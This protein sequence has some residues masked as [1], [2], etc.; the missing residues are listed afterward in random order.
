MDN[1]LENISVLNPRIY[2][3]II[4]K[5]GQSLIKVVNTVDNDIL[6]NN[7][8][9]ETTKLDREFHGYGIESMRLLVKKYNGY[10]SFNQ[11]ED[12]FSLLIVLPFN[13]SL[14]E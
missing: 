14:I 11:E 5:K 6:K 4:M 8:N 13:D 10:L 1:A 2:L 9:M 12:E 3:S 7:P